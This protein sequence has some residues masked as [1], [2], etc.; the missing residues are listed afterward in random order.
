MENKLLGR[1]NFLVS[2]DGG[3]I[4]FF[5]HEQQRVHVIPS[6]TIE[7]RYISYEELNSLP[8]QDV[9]KVAYDIID[10]YV[11]NYYEGGWHSES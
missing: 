9:L 4:T 10:D 11:N 2:L 6:V 5:N 7:S 1:V 3:G 8:M